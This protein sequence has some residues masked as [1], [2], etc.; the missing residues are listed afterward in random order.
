M[1]RRF[2]AYFFIIAAFVYLTG[3]MFFANRFGFHT[4][5][6]GYDVSFCMPADVV[7]SLVED[8]QN[9]VISF[10]M[11]D[12]SVRKNT[13]SD[14]GLFRESDYAVF[15]LPSAGFS[16]PVS[17]V[18]DTVY[19]LNDA[20]SF[21]HNFV[22]P[23]WVKDFCVKAE[24]AYALR[25]SDGSY[26]FVSEKS[27]TQLDLT[28]LR[29]AVL[30][31]ANG[32]F[33]V[34]VKS[35]VEPSRVFV[36]DDSLLGMYGFHKQV[37]LDLGAGVIYTLSDADWSVFSG[38]DD[39]VFWVD[40]V[41]L[42]QFVASLAD[43]YDTYDKPRIFAT[44][45][46]STVSLVTRG[47]GRCDFPGWKMDQA[48]LSDML[49]VEVFS[50]E[51]TT[52]LVSWEFSGKSHSGCDIGDTYVEISLNDQK[53]WFYENGVCVV[54]TD[55]VTGQYGDPARQTPPGVFRTTDFYKEHTMTGS[56]GS[57]FCH[58]FIRVTEDGIGIHDSD[59]SVFGGSVYLY[60][61]SHGCINTPYDAEKQIFEK[62]VSL[63]DWVPVV[64]W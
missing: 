61:G 3:C 36:Y 31:A 20:V 11:P 56:Y 17:L 16:W 43:K 24:D 60:D 5:L 41:L 40:P 53:M 9:E 54:E 15:S 62:L 19:S 44:S 49:R 26:R 34:D 23:D 7:A 25:Q 63:N 51:D 38:Y 32:S 22:V 58:Y 6:N 14:L 28:R 12:G 13:F 21:H 46:G 18:R 4:Y 1:I 45:V 57:A 30:T 42:D 48:Y 47:V 33:C 10:D 39:G 2:C 8:T 59:R 37:S 35:C 27:G 50:D 64:I 52:V 29:D 55:V